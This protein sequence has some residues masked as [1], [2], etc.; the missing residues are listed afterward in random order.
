MK[1]WSPLHTRPQWVLPRKDSGSRH[2]RGAVSSSCRS[3]SKYR[4]QPCTV[5]GSLGSPHHTSCQ[6]HRS[7]ITRSPSPT[8]GLRPPA[9]PELMIHSTFP[10]SISSVAARAAFTFPIPERV[11]VPNPALLH[12]SNSLCIATIIPVLIKASSGNLESVKLE[13]FDLSANLVKLHR[14]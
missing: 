1:N 4:G 8:S 9:Q 11:T 2:R 7:A 5:P 10:L 12:D 6:A 13:F 14:F 3:A